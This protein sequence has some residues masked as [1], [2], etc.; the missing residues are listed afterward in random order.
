MNIYDRDV[1]LCRVIKQKKYKGDNDPLVSVKG[2]KTGE[3]WSL[4]GFDHNLDN[5][6]NKTSVGIS[7]LKATERTS[8][9]ST[10]HR[11]A[12]LYGLNSSH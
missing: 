4:L 2:N 1:H 9:S 5:S 11:V 10:L 7:L 12:Y 6:P 8:E 3:E